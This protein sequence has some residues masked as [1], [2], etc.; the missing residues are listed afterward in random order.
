MWSAINIALHI[1]SRPFKN[2]SM[3]NTQNKCRQVIETESKSMVKHF[4]LGLV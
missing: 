2:S 3:G 4:P 1:L